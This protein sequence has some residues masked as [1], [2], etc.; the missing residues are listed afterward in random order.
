MLNQFCTLLTNV[1]S[2]ALAKSPICV[3]KGTR[4]DKLEKIKKGDA[5]IE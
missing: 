2:G 3:E 1:Y 5:E 4:R